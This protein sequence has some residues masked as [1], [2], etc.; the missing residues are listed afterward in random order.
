MKRI[1][2]LF[3]SLLLL[4][5]LYSQEDELDVAMEDG[6]FFFLDEDYQEA[7]F[8]YLKLVD[9]GR[10]NENLNYKIGLCYLNIPGEE[11]KAISFLEKAIENTTDKYKARSSAE[12]KA[13]IHSYFYLARAYH[14]NNELDKALDMYNQFK[15]LPEFEGNYNVS[16]VDDEISACEKAK[17]IQ[18]IPISIKVEN[19]G[20]PVNSDRNNY[21]PVISHDENYLVFMSELAFYDGVFTS[22]KIEGKWT[23]P[24]NITSQIESD[25]DAIPTCL[26]IDGKELYLVKGEENNRDI[27]VSRLENGAWSKMERLN[28]NVNSGRAESHVSISA[29]GNTLYISSNRRGGIGEMDIWKSIKSVSGNWG[30]AMNLGPRINTIYDEE[31]PFLTGDD[32]ILIFSSRGHYNMGNFDIFYSN[33]LDDNSWSIPSNIGFPLNSTGD[34]FFY[35][36]V[37]DENTGYLAR[38]RPEGLGGMDIYRYEILP[39]EKEIIKPFSGIIDLQGMKVNAEKDFEI[40]I[41][42]KLTGAVIATIRFDKEK[43]EFTYE[44][45]TGNYSFSIKKE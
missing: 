44:T 20:S 14:I 34:D 21:N 41:K 32:K 18:D 27:F 2:I 9:T 31:T 16:M 38:I 11:H 26:S 30:P 8:Y 15:A 12:T 45:A 33:L 24:E 22:R 42:D 37:R 17:I 19:I 10:M 28:D 7:I 13:P 1:I 3:L 43:G 4:I 39:E 23:E 29:D 25:G 6:D 36:P 35:S 40:K 5:P